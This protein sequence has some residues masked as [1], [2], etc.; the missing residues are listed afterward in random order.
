MLAGWTTEISPTAPATTATELR[1]QVSAV[2]AAS[3]VARG[4][5]VTLGQPLIAK[6]QD[7]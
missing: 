2:C 7:Q 4:L 3:T 5:P 1:T 6:D